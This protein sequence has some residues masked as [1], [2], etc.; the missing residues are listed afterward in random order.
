MG[1]TFS[2]NQH[3]NSQVILFIANTQIRKLTALQALVTFSG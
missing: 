1:Q 2:I 3:A